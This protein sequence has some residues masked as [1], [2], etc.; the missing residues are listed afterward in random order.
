MNLTEGKQNK[1][2]KYYD[3]FSRIYDW[4][5]SK[6]YYHKPRAVAIKELELNQNQTVLKQFYSL[7]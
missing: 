5:S 7:E 1:V 6:S 4:I 2:T 3:K